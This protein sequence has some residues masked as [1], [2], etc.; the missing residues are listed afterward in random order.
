[1]FESISKLSLP[2][3]IFE[4]QDGIWAISWD[5][6]LFHHR[7]GESQYYSLDP[8]NEVR[9][10]TFFELTD[11]IILVGSNAGLF[12]FDRIQK[13]IIPVEPLYAGEQIFAMQPDA[14][15]K[16]W[17][18]CRRSLL[19]L[20]RQN[21]IDYFESKPA[22]TLPL[23]FT[24]QQG[25]ASANFG[26][27]TSSVG[28]MR[29]N[30]E[31]W[32]ASVRGAIH[33]FPERITGTGEPLR[34]AVE[35]VFANGV[36]YPVK[37]S[38]DVPPGT[39]NLEFR[40]AVLGGRA[41]E[42]PVFRYRLASGD[43]PW[44]ESSSALATFNRLSPGEYRFEVQARS[45]ALEWFGPAAAIR[46]SIQPFWYQRPW[47]IALFTLLILLGILLA[48]RYR[49]AK[50]ERARQELEAR[51]LSRTAELALARDEAERLRH[52]AVAAAEAKANF[53]ATMSHEI[54]T[55]MNGVI[56]MIE[57]L[58]GTK[59]DED[60]QRIVEVVSSSGN[61]LVGIVNDIL[62][63]SKIEAGMLEIDEAPFS[64]DEL[65]DQ[66]ERLFAP[67][68]AAKLIGFS[69]WRDPSISPWRHGN[70]ARI[71]QI[72]SN[73]IANAI[74]FTDLGE[75][76]L[77]I[78][79]IGGT[80]LQFT[81]QD[82]GIGIPLSKLDAIFE[83]FTQAESTTTRRFGG[84]GLGLAISQRLAQVLKGS[85]KVES[86]EGTGST[87]TLILDLPATT[88]PAT[89]V[90]SDLLA[91]QNRAHP[92]VV[93]VVE[94]NAVNRHVAQSLLK[95]LGCEVLTA[96]DGLEAL[97]T[98]CK[99]SLDLVLMDCHMP[100]MDGF[101]ATRRIRALDHPNSEVAIVALSAGVLQ[102]EVQKC[103]Q[104]GMNHFLAKP[105]RSDELARLLFDLSKKEEG[106]PFGWPSSQSN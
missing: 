46:L 60:Q 99:V 41:G 83:P 33:F 61:S 104:A 87:F 75:V 13:T 47:V 93:L 63:L 69:V 65:V 22:R 37:A 8:K 45:N 38:L 64:L 23:R 89:L 26:L 92:F 85:L 25:M 98:A 34:C 74:K 29:K 40:Y 100:R 35:A 55:P 51:V 6:G 7:E 17:F 80:Q 106:Q 105:V 48:F 36:K 68:A 57:I 82:S 20:P 77:R 84:T 24:A 32:F 4:G 3:G 78:E 94:D 43:E 71:T 2:R 101:D 15:G 96:I 31:I 59:L 5:K 19:A 67:M 54:R 21:L 58:R 12:G 9:Y 91:F 86:I 28:L 79:Q 62:S 27:G 90:E 72:L 88:A 103:R 56:G 18:G 50:V 1:V 95:R 14:Q 81:V 76:S 52:E 44:I 16:L 10:F 70:S 49:S 53:L 42:P 102:Q 73:L 30:G 11:R 97:E 39:S 66:I